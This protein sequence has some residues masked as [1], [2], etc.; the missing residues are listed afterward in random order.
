VQVLDVSRRLVQLRW[1]LGGGEGLDVVWMVTREPGLLALDQGDLL[2][3]LLRLRLAAGAAGADVLAIVDRRPS[4]LLQDV[5]FT[6]ETLSEQ[7][8]AWEF[9]LG[10][11]GESEWGSRFAALRAY[12]E[13]HGDAHAGFR[14]GDDAEL[15]RWCELQR[16]A[17]KRGALPQPREEALG[18]LGFEWDA[19]AAEWRRWLS[20]WRRWKDAGGQDGTGG[21]PT[22]V[23]FYLLNWASVQRV[24][25]RTRFLPADR[26]AA[27]TAL[28]FDWEASD[29]LS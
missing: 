17:K 11:D 21:S 27:L 23:D 22:A 19:A 24:A 8:R 13:R 16:D 15:A 4:L 29:P 9:G 20:E 3:R 25:R 14:D 28:G 26:V 10:G 5:A 12:A 7:L 2:A 18:G 1:A 6:A